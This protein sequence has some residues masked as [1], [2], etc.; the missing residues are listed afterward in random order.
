MFL[1]HGSLFPNYWID[2]ARYSLYFCYVVTYICYDRHL[3]VDFTSLLVFLQIVPMFVLSGG[4]KNH[5][6]IVESK[7]K[8]ETSVAFVL[9]SD[10]Q[11]TVDAFLASA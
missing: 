7:L 1:D 2:L 9:T 11:Q 5:V 3:V 4:K 6:Q 8:L 10:E